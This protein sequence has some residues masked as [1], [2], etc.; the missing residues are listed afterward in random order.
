MEST[1]SVVRVSISVSYPQRSRHPLF[2][3]ESSKAKRRAKR[4][5]KNF[6]SPFKRNG[7]LRKPYVVVGMVYDAEYR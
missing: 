5:T 6:T 4:N 1:L 2:V 3:V 7:R